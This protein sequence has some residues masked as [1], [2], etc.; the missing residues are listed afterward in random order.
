M[1]EG[2]PSLVNLLRQGTQAA[3]ETAAGALHSLANHANNR[4]TIA[5]QE[6]IPALVAIFE[7]GTANA[8][9]EALGALVA[10]VRGS[11][12]NQTG[13]ANELVAVLG[14]SASSHE[15]KAWATHLMRDLA[16][17]A[18]NRKP[19]C[20]AG[21]IL[22]LVPQV[23]DGSDETMTVAARALS[24]IALLSSQHRAQVTAQ[25]I[26]L[27][28]S[29]AVETRQRAAFAL[30]DMA[31]LGQGGGSGSGSS[32][33][34]VAMAGGMERFETLLRDGSV[35]AQE[36][37]LWLMCQ[38][39]DKVSKI[40]IATARVEA[41][42]VRALV[43]GQLSSVAEEHAAAVLLRLIAGREA[44]EPDL[45][46]EAK[47][48]IIGAG[49][50]ACFVRLI[51]NSFWEARRHAASILAELCRSTD[52][53]S[54]ARQLA[55]AASGAVEGLCE[56]LTSPYAGSCEFVCNAFEQLS[57][58]N[59]DVRYIVA[60]SGAIEQ[61]VALT[62]AEHA[63][64]VQRSAAS[65]LAALAEGSDANQIEI[66]E[67]GA[68]PAL[69]ALLRAQPTKPHKGATR[70]LWQLST[71]ADVQVVVAREGGLGPLMA[72]LKAEADGTREAAAAAVAALASD[73]AE[74]QAAFAC[75]AAI[76]PLV[77]LLGSDSFDTR[78]FAQTALLSI[79]SPSPAARD[80]VI[81][82]LV[83]LLGVRNATAQMKAAECLATLAGRTAACRLAIATAGAIQPL[84]R[85][86]GDGRNVSRTQLRAA[87]VL[88][89]LARL[90]ECRQEIVTCGGVPPLVQVL[91]SANPEAQVRSSCAL[92]NLS[93]LASAQQQISEI[94]GSVQLLVGLLSSEHV[95]ASNHAACTLWHLA[96]TAANKAAM[97]NSGGV[98]PLIR[99]L[100]RSKSPEAV[101]SISALLADLV[102]S[103]QQGVGSNVAR[104]T[105]IRSGGLAPLI[106]LLEI[107]GDYTNG[108]P[109]LQKHAACALWGLTSDL[110]YHAVLVAEGAVPPLIK[111]TISAHSEAQGYAAA[112]L[113]NLARDGVARGKM[114]SLGAVA[115][116]TD[117]SHNKTT[118]AWLRAQVVGVLECIDPRN[119]PGAKLS[120]TKGPGS[121]RKYS[122][123]RASPPKLGG[124]AGNGPLSLGAGKSAGPAGM[125]DRRRGDR[126]T[127]MDDAM[128]MPRRPGVGATHRTMVRRAAKRGSIIGPPGSTLETTDKREPGLAEESNSAKPAPPT[129]TAAAATAAAIA[130]VLQGGTTPADAAK[131]AVAAVQG[132]A[133]HEAAPTGA[134]APAASAVP[135][136]T[137]NAPYRTRT[138]PNGVA[139][140][141]KLTHAQPQP[142]ATA[143]AA[144]EATMRDSHRPQ[145]SQRPQSSHR[146][147]SKLQA[148]SRV[149][150]APTVGRRTKK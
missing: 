36:Y 83:A 146:A 110:K 48:A 49:G 94:D 126:T 18:E 71:N 117:I 121:P 61:L 122:P 19:L 46:E 62:G 68:I 98:T 93:P 143:R 42:I 17:N 52:G 86:L 120:S 76:Q 116:L 131:A 99:L 75:P 84:I 26:R 69:L 134:K 149:A 56:W 73:H 78:Q 67:H 35:E 47:E 24:N 45:R 150:G 50:M 27:L 1:A 15:A 28:T 60:E 25:L 29:D 8:K 115:S 81:E 102:R 34:T 2:I 65:A 101:E 136:P 145:A 113:C 119:H 22:Q 138:G 53:W 12:P 23:R 88:S 31:S 133:E 55:V 140:R 39:T 97:V 144:K 118:N 80:A 82:P 91:A 64:E 32:K 59:A 16:L 128:E 148:S 90:V 58:A 100:E 125:T 132:R 79:A 4:E 10:L 66:F 112:A 124:A 103:Q 21:A 147:A 87:A 9:A 108:A 105:L 89:D 41:S 127:R 130:A 11:E 123:P 3:Q 63:P 77:A 74:N 96:S 137:H 51:G 109:K 43:G 142:D 5:R 38:A 129:S 104:E 44:V 54:G 106:R 95:A 6:G 141:L 7:V 92:S 85:L 20:K 135:N 57:R 139:L 40:A 14:R 70:A 37:T 13:V 33:I 30:R 111:A 107:D 72:M 114:I